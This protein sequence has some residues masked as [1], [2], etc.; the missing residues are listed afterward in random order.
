MST[1]WVPQTGSQFSGNMISLVG[2]SAVTVTDILLDSNYTYNTGGDCFGWFFVASESANLTDI[3]FYAKTIN[4]TG[5]TDGNLNWEVR[6]SNAATDKPGSTLT[7]SGTWATDGTTGWK[8]IS[9]LSAALTAGK[10]YWVI[11]GDSDGDATNNTTISAASGALNLGPAMVSNFVSSTNGFT[12]SSYVARQAFGAFKVGS[13]WHGGWPFNTLATTTSG[14]YERGCRFKLREP[15]TLVGFAD[16]QDS[17]ASESG[18]ISK[19]YADA[20]SPG[21]T[22]L[23]TFTNSTYTITGTRPT[24]S[25][26]IIPAASRI[27]LDAETWYRCVVKTASS[28]THPRKNT[29]PTTFPADLKTACFPSSGDCYWTEES[30]GSWSDDSSALSLFGPL[31]VPKTVSAGG[32]T[33]GVIGS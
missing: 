15:M 23:L 3:I 2:D 25:R 1:T 31:L 4:G 5:S 26:L 18:S 7:A 11:I 24:G 10:Y 13:V 8:T 12:A 28:V 16:P 19:I 17:T 30:G 21:G 27:D 9:G 22:T 32:G 6:E 33:A 20:T 14:T 29:G